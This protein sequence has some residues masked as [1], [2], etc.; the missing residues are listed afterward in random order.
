MNRTKALDTLNEIY[1]VYKDLFGESIVLHKD[2]ST[3]DYAIVLQ[4][5]LTNSLRELIQPILDKN[6][7]AIKETK[8]FVTIYSV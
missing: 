2:A 7:L 5:S 4:A 8:G 1:N 3:K 6:N